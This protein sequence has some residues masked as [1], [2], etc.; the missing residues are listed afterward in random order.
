MPRRVLTA[1][2]DGKS[3]FVSDGSVPSAHDYAA[4]PGFST[5]I[6]WTTPQAA[7]LADLTPE[8][9][10]LGTPV[11]PPQAGATSLVVV[12]FPPDESLVSVDPQAAAAEQSEWLPGMVEHFDPQ[13]PGMHKT[14]TIDYCIV[15]EGEVCL[16]LDDGAL[17]ELRTGDVV[18]QR[19]TRHAWRNRSSK[20]AAVAYVLIGASAAPM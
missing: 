2:I 19:G 17:R 3:V 16:E 8:A 18:I 11:V 12:R 13:A 15:I 20:S 7:P 9:A 6:L 10:P 1:N 4:I 14:N 5:A